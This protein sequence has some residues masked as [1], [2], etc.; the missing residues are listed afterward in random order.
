MILFR[1]DNLP[2][3]AMPCHPR[4]RREDAAQR[5]DIADQKRNSENAPGKV[6]EF[7]GAGIMVYGGT[8]VR[9]VGIGTSPYTPEIGSEGRPQGPKGLVTVRPPGGPRE[10]RDGA[11]SDSPPHPIALRIMTTIKLESEMG[12]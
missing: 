11:W 10:G 5:P 12:K 3:R 8:G 4:Y 9:Q 7:V 6:E 2:C 1:F